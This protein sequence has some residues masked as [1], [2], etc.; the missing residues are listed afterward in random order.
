MAAHK[1]DAR[2]H[3]QMQDIL[4]IIAAEH[5]AA[6]ERQGQRHDEASD[7]AIDCALDGAASGPVASKG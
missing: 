1:R 7:K 4:D 2:G 3:V 5:F 6:D